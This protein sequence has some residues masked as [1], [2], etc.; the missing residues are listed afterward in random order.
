M[1]PIR[2]E[3][4]DIA[5]IADSGQC[6]RINPLGPGLWRA[7]AG[8][9]CLTIETPEDGTVR[10]LCSEEQYRNFWYSYFDLSEDYSHFLRAVPLSDGYLTQAARRSSGIR[11]LRQDPWEVLVSFIISQQKNI[12]A[13]KRSVEL[14][15]RRYGVSLGEGV[16]AFPTP[17]A[18]AEVPE[19]ELLACSLGYRAKYIRSVALTVAEGKADLGTF[20]FMEDEALL[21]ALMQFYGVGIKV[22]HCVMLF[23]FHRMSAFPRDVWINRVLQTEYPDGFPLERYEGFAGVIQ[24]YMFYYARTCGN[25]GKTASTDCKPGIFPMK[26]AEAEAKLI[27]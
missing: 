7:V 26:D 10:L 4:F 6:F 21:C 5:A 14:L 22:A 13:I 1:V 25:D 8:R 9:E 16:Y 19:E 11:I 24:Q 2:Q 23:G 3:N 20:D 17:E 27:G 15:S 18:L 12:P